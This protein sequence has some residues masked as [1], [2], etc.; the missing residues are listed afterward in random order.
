L[1]LHC[2]L[3][4]E[5]ELELVLALKYGDEDAGMHGFRIESN[6]SV[7]GLIVVRTRGDGGGMLGV[8]EHCVLCVFCA[9]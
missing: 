5:L 1:T 3:K 8:F 4:L 7:G 6:G 9:F 2:E